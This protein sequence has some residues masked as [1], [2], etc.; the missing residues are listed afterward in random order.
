MKKE[1][2]KP[3]LYA[4]HAVRTSAVAASNWTSFEEKLIRSLLAEAYR[5]M[6]GARLCTSLIDMEGV[7]SLRATEYAKWQVDGT[8]KHATLL[9][10]ELR[11]SMLRRHP[12]NHRCAST[13]RTAKPPRCC[14]LRGRNKVRTSYQRKSRE[15]KNATRTDAKRMR[16][17]TATTHHAPLRS[18]T[19]HR[20]HHH[21]A[22]PADP[23]V[24]LRITKPNV[25]R[26]LAEEPPIKLAHPL[27][28]VVR[29]RQ[30]RVYGRGSAQE[31]AQD[32][33]LIRWPGWLEDA[34]DA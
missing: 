23:P 9:R 28:L 7:P 20:A 3:E 19:A 14:G 24:L 21:A 33:Q 26:K 6:A 11:L 32:L 31:A 5:D 2:K 30:S 10:G 4:D 25:L 8:S 15:K 29:H 17:T 1:K 18:R 34:E 12:E 27:H 13:R 16:N 22:L